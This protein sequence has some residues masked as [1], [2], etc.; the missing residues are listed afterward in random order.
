LSSDFSNPSGSFALPKDFDKVVRL[1]PL[2]SVVLFPGVVQAL[3]IFEPRYRQLA[4]DAIQSDELI[5]M[6]IEDV[7]KA[8]PG[9]PRPELLPTVCVGK[10]VS[11]NQFEDG[12]YNLLL[13]G[14]ARARIT[15]EIVTDHPYRMAQVELLE[16]SFQY[17]PDDV[18]P[19][20]KQVLDLFRVLVEQRGISDVEP[21]ARLFKGDVPLGQLS[22]LIC[23]ACGA[24]PVQQQR[25]LEETEICRRAEILIRILQGLIAKPTSDQGP[26]IDFPPEF[27]D[28]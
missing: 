27:S 12:R 11:H 6:A 10:I 3:H 24:E 20:T 2:P 14:S 28:N 9:D 17:A 19:L 13:V 21:L 4:D 7:E 8:S 15:K 22:D 5:T 26:G 23:Y 1:F 16:D 18:E 25:V